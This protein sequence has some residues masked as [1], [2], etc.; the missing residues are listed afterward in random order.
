LKIK[1]AISGYYN[2]E[3]RLL[4]PLP[5]L[6]INNLTIENKKAVSGYYNLVPPCTAFANQ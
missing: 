5:S 4:S 3:Y 1:K 6:A 2:L